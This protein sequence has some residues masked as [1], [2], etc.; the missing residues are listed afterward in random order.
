[1]STQPM[2]TPA[3]PTIPEDTIANRLKLARR[4]LSIRRAAL[5]C[6]IGRGTWQNWENG[7]REPRLSELREIAGHLNVRFDWLVEG[8]PLADPRRNGGDGGGMG[9]TGD[10]HRYLRP[11]PPILVPFVP[12][13]PPVSAVPVSTKAA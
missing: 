10:T 13:V 8:G 4:H 6:G 2:D 11:V 1:M 12:L 5:L 9:S 7:V 3:P